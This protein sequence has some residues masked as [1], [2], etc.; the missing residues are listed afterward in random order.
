MCRFQFH[1]I[2]L[3][4]L[5]DW[6]RLY[7][8]LNVYFNQ[9]WSCF[10][11][12]V[13]LGYGLNVVYLLTTRRH[14]GNTRLLNWIRCNKAEAT[15]QL[16][17][18]CAGRDAGRVWTGRDTQTEVWVGGDFQTQPDHLTAPLSLCVCV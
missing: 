12:S 9:T 16:V 6:H 4:H 7:S 15:K 13:Y 10:Q 2:N 5:D 18:V 8:A 11:K 14:R 3:G 1:K 17:R